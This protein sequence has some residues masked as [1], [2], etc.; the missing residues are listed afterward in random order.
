MRG[1]A[2]WGVTGLFGMTLH[3]ISGTVSQRR[4]RDP[5]SIISG[6]MLWSFCGRAIPERRVDVMSF[7]PDVRF[8]R[9]CPV[10]LAALKK[11]V[12]SGSSKIEA[13]AGFFRQYPNED[14]G[15]QD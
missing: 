1:A 10:C 11:R 15:D 14:A 12:V 7:V 2:R 5:V 6:P 4:G 9:I 8:R 13:G 3:A